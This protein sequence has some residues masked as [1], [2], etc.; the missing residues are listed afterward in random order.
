MTLY[1][2]KTRNRNSFFQLHIILRYSKL[3]QNITEP[4]EQI[5]VGATGMDVVSLSVCLV[6]SGSA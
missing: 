1:I 6:V 5:P 3:K 4:T 2:K